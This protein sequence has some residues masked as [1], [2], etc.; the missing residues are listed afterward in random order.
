[1]LAPFPLQR[2]LVRCDERDAREVNPV[3]RWVNIPAN[4]PINPLRAAALICARGQHLL[5]PTALRQRKADSTNPSSHFALQ[6][7]A[8]QQHPARTPRLQTASTHSCKQPKSG[9]EGSRGCNSTGYLHQQATCFYLSTKSGLISTVFVPKPS[10]R[11]N[12]AAGFS[13]AAITPVPPSQYR[14]HLITGAGNYPITMSAPI[15]H[16]LCKEETRCILKTESGK[17]LNAP[18]TPS[19]PGS[20]S[21]SHGCVSWKCWWLLSRSSSAAFAATVCLSQTKSI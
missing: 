6:P 12:S 3:N 16:C 14:S 18:K 9:K 20:R 11:G 1:M 15:C 21:T 8:E 2:C 19:P 17:I 4:V 10:L 7:L 13:N 5:H